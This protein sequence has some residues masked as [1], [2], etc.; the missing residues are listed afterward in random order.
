MGFTF[1]SRGKKPKITI[2]RDKPDNEEQYYQLTKWRI[3]MDIMHGL[4]EFIEFIE[5]V[6]GRELK[7]WEKEYVIKAMNIEVDRIEE[8]ILSGS[9]NIEEPIG[10]CGF[11]GAG[12]NQ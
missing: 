8:E 3:V 7:I 1:L 6:A 9:G 2:R 12:K 4:I 11:S 5:R 10:L